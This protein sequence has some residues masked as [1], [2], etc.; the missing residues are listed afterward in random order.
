MKE[1]E[2]DLRLIQR[3]A[4]MH[5]GNAMAHIK[6][7]EQRER[8]DNVRA[9]WSPHAMLAASSVVIA[10][11]YWS[12]ISPGKAVLAYGMGAEMYRRMGHSY[13]LALA[14]ASVNEDE[15]ARMP[16][17]VEE[18]RVPTAQTVAFALICNEVSSN[19]RNSRYEL[20]NTHWKHTGNVPIGRLGIPLDHYGRCANAMRAAR[21]EKNIDRFL[22]EAGNYVHRAAEI[23]RTASHD[24]F[25]WRRLQSTI[26]PAEP[27]AVAI[28]TALSVISH[29]VFQMPITEMSN[30]DPYGRL[31]VEIGEKMRNAAVGGPS[32]P[33]LGQG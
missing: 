20:L 9:A 15:M 10:A 2:F 29:E 12:L 3:V 21:E 26:L 5:E 14:L 1:I 25:H 18:T 8:G 7:D 11:S 24:R 27:E 30:L 17:V 13:W 6:R 19:H 32:Q 31:L 28:T 23:V 4:L 33:R 22:A 16:S